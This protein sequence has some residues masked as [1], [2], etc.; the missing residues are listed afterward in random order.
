MKQNGSRLASQLPH[1]IPAVAAHPVWQPSPPEQRDKR[2]HTVVGYQHY[3]DPQ[4][5]CQQIAGEVCD[6]NLD[7]ADLTGINGKPNLLCWQHTCSPFVAPS[8][9]QQVIA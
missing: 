2:G 4:P 8:H 3:G 9:I 1:E 5:P 7:P 6:V